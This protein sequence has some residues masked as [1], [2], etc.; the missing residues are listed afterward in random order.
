MNTRRLRLALVASLLVLAPVAASAARGGDFTVRDLKGKRLR[1]S[2]FKKQVVLMTFWATWCKPCLTE[3]K[4]LQKL[5]KK[6]GRKGFVVLGVNIDGPETRGKVRSTVR[7]Y[8]LTFPVFIDKDDRVVRRFNPK[9]VSPFSVLMAPG[10]R[11]VKTRSSFQVSDVPAIERE[12]TGLLAR[13][14]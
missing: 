5:Y 14:K 8:K 1:L 9:K 7:R 2:D 4:H 3:L 6:Y 11:I 12:V 10:N 13:R